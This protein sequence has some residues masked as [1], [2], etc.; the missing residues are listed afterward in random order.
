M[1]TMMKNEKMDATTAGKHTESNRELFIAASSDSGRT[2]SKNERV[3]T[4]VCPC[5]KTALVTNSAG[6]VYVGWRQVLPGDLRHIAVASSPDQGKTFTTPVIVSDDQW[7]LAGCP[8]SGATLAANEDGSVRALWYSEGKNG[9]TGL[10]TSTTRDDGATFSPRQLVAAALTRGTPVLISGPDGP[11]AIWQ[12]VESNTSEVRLSSRVGSETGANSFLI[13]GN[14]ESPAA[15]A[16][17]GKL[18]LAY[19]AKGDAHRDV[20][21]VTGR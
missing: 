7:V 17:A 13:A 12:Q 9:R 16:G 3:A 21:L 15:A 19:I 14:G 10:Y 2:F 8:V 11:A 1:K 20:W 4:N 5:C 18:F 6:R